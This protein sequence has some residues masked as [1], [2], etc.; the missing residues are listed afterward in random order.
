MKKYLLLIFLLGTLLM[1]LVME[2]T[3][4]SLKTT[5]TPLGILN[6]EFANNTTKI[7]TVL[8]A[9]APTPPADNIEAAINNTYYDFLFLFFY[10]FFLFFACKKIASVI[11][12]FLANAGN[13]IAV[14]ALLAG[15]FDVLENTGMLLSLNGHTAGGIAFL[16]TFF[17]VIKWCFVIVAVLYVLTGVL[18]LAYRKLKN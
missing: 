15:F 10:A 2:K 5:A 8:N 4:A 12:G 13:I 6:L 18:I 16:T 9:W 7:T 14:M 1:M 17:S 3:G 11:N